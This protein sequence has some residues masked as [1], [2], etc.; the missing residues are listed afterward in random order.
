MP[1]HVAGSIMEMDD[2]DNQLVNYNQLNLDD[3]ETDINS[4]FPDVALV[5]DNT[6]QIG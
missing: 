1:E 5:E 2:E 4:V 3:A 6:I